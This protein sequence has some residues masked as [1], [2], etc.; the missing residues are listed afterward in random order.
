MYKRPTY[1]FVQLRDE[2]LIAQMATPGPLMLVDNGGKAY[3]LAFP[4]Q[5]GVGEPSRSAGRAICVLIRLGC[6]M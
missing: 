5:G 1:N 3:Q 4:T 6:G 2:P